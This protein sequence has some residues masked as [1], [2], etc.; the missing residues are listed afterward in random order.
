[1]FVSRQAIA[2]L[3]PAPYVFS[4]SLQNVLFTLLLFIS[5]LLIR[6]DSESEPSERRIK[7]RYADTDDELEDGEVEEPPVGVTA[8]SVSEA[9]LLRVYYFN[10]CSSLDLT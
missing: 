2:N 9:L 6:T 10:A 4:S 3:K 7:P 8:P 1:M 5:S